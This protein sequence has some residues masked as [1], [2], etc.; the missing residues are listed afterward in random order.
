MRASLPQFTAQSASSERPIRVLLVDDSNVVR[1]IFT[2]MLGDNDE[3]EIAGEAANSADALQQLDRLRVDIILLDIEMPERSGLDALPDI[4]EA[5]NGARVLVV[6][7][8]A[9]ENGPAA[10]R[11]LELGACDTL[12]KPGRFG[13]SG[14]FPDMLVEK[15]VRL[16]RSARPVPV[17]DLPRESEAALSELGG[18]FTAPECIA[19]GASTG[20]IPIIYEIVRNLPGELDCP[21]FIAQHLPDAFME[22]FA[23]QLSSQT[24]RRV[25]VPKAGEEIMPRTIYISPGNV[26]LTCARAGARRKIRYLEHYAGSRYSPSVD[27]LFESVADVYGSSALA[28]VLSG[29]GNDGANGALQLFRQG[30]RIVVQ[31]ADSSVVWGMPGAIAK[32]GL[33]NAIM[34]PPHISR[35]LAQA[36]KS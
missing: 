19:I 13:F 12:A 29:M 27:A 32:A 11:A 9:E 36:V 24:D 16:G 20:G 25:C 6:S 2:R 5:G 34:S 10:I 4:I 7:S 33:A 18:E 28:L 30:A 14:R 35:L 17:R 26:H 21:I 15:V 8:F 1:S 3:I 23:R 22:F 31:D